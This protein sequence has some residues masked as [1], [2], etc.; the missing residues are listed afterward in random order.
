MLVYRKQRGRALKMNPTKRRLL[1]EGYF[2]SLRGA[3]GK[4]RYLAKLSVIN[5]F[6]PYESERKDWNDDVDLWPGIT[7]VHLG[8]Y[9]LA[10]PSPYTGED[11][12]N[13]KSLDCYVNFISGWVREVLV[14][15]FDDKRVVIGKVI[16]A[17]N[18]MLFVC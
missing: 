14:K 3:D 5:G 12:L 6:D 11:L 8:M 13:Y 10:T 2:S 7:Y 9:L 1:L 15:S 18:T 4:K 17:S 16:Y